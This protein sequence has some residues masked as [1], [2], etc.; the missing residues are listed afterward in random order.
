MRRHIPPTAG[1]G[2]RQH[3]AVVVVFRP[4]RLLPSASR[5]VV[6]RRC[7]AQNL[8][9]LFAFI[10]RV[11]ARDFNCAAANRWEFSC[12]SVDSG[13]GNGGRRLYYLTINLITRCRRAVMQNAPVQVHCSPLNC[14]SMFG[15]TLKVAPLSVTAAG[16]K[17]QDNRRRLR[18]TSVAR[19]LRESVAPC[20]CLWI[21]FFFV[22]WSF[23]RICVDWTVAMPSNED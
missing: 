4:H 15:T 13:I 21:V 23:A 17:R 2:K 14:V 7:G 6:W 1:H 5:D 12:A 8:T 16:R 3:A 19:D 10:V 11:A 22:A 20:C 9:H 18:R